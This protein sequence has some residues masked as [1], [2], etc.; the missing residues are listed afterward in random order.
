MTT[1]TTTR[2]YSIDPAHSDISFA[3]R[4]L[5]L[6]KI[7][8]TFH[9]L[10]GTIR[11]G[12]SGDVP[13]K[14]E[15]EIDVTTVDTQEPKRDGHLQA[16]DFFNSAEHSKMKFVSTSINGSGS[17]FTVTGDLTLRGVTKSVTLNGT[18]AGHV[19]DPWGNDRI[20]WSATTRINRA[21]FGITFN[22][23]IAGGGVMLGDDVDVTLEIQAI[24]AK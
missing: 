18:V 24:P 5:M 7:R 13:T 1:T 23:P 16:P 15:A 6:T 22:Q 19:T 3:I 11:L 14:I 17:T 8:G 10:T 2:T 9:G 12:E 4:H 20:G 21:D